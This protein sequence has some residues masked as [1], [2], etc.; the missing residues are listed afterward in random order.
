VLCTFFGVS[1]VV[2]STQNE[3]DNY[4]YLLA[5]NF[6]NYLPI[7]IFFHWQTQQLSFLNLVIDNPTTR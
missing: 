1:S 4:T 5:G 3:R 2:A 6:A 7:L